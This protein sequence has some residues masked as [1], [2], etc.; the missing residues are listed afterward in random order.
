MKEGRYEETVI[1]SVK[2]LIQ[3]KGKKVERERLRALQSCN[4]W[5]LRGKSPFSFTLWSEETSLGGKPAASETATST[6]RIDDA[7]AA[8]R[9]ASRYILTRH[10]GEEHVTACKER[11]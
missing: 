4:T 1:L 8:E 10:L 7:T 6:L 5:P 11:P 2:E 3:K 9:F